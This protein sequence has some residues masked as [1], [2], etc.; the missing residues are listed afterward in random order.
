MILYNNTLLWAY[1]VFTDSGITK[2][3]LGLWNVSFSRRLHDV[4]IYITLHIT[5][6]LASFDVGGHNATHRKNDIETEKS[7]FDRDNPCIDYTVVATGKRL[8]STEG[9][10]LLINICARQ[11][12]LS[13]RQPIMHVQVNQ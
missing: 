1:W 7:L 13:M 3:R 9:Y 2:H 5:G 4:H 6:Q 10:Q 12:F 11:A 8:S